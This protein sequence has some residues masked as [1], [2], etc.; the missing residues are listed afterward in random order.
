MGR[1]DGD[2]S[3]HSERRSIA[4]SPAAGKSPDSVSLVSLVY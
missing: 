1:A 4:L 2:V 3:V